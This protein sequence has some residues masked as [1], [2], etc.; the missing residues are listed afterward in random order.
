MFHKMNLEDIEWLN[1]IIEKSD[2]FSNDYSPFN[3]LGWSL[4]YH[5]EIDN[6]SNIL[7]G[8]IK[9]EDDRWTYLYPIGNGDTAALISRLEK[10]HNSE[11]DYPFSMICNKYQSELIDNSYYKVH[12]P[13]YDDYIYDAEDLAYLRGSKYHSKRNLIAQFEKKYDYNYEFFTKDNLNDCIELMKRWNMK[14]NEPL[15]E[16]ELKLINLAANNA[17]TFKI[18][19]IVLY[20]G[21]KPIAFSVASMPR[22]GLMDVHMEKADTEYTGVYSKIMNLLSKYAYEVEN[23]RYI[24]REEDMGIENLRK[25]KKSLHPEFMEEKYI[26]TKKY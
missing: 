13:E 9:L 14:I 10:M 17:K 7:V 16:N 24:N 23:I 19:G 25:A 21:N 4:S 18:L 3:I 6:I 1:K 8:R 12:C 11:F 20:S 26:C 2:C 22:E 5:T 15:F